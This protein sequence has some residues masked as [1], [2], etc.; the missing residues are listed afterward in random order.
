MQGV[1]PSMVTAQHLFDT[2]DH[3]LDPLNTSAELDK[4]IVEDV[5]LNNSTV[6]FMHSK[7]IQE[8]S[9]TTTFFYNL[10]ISPISAIQ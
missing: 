10:F 2:K 7:T 6:H 9:I 3:I 1:T 5:N 8:V 4:Y